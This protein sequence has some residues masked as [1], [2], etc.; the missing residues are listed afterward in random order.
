MEARLKTLKHNPAIKRGIILEPLVLKKVE[1][2]VGMKFKS[3][4]LHLLPCWPIFGASPDGINEEFVVE[5]K[6]PSTTQAI[7]NYIKENG[8]ISEKFNA[9]IQL[10]MLLTGRK[11]GYFCVAHS[12]FEKSGNVEVKLVMY[13]DTFVSDLLCRSQ[14]FWRTYVFPV[15]L[16]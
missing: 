8:Y 6:C 15:F 16:N 7:K 5:I 13:D 11:K 14:T 10:Q 9:Q 4:G 1:N 3:S 12:D 2:L